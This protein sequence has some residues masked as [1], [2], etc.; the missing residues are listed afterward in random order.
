MSKT[1]IAA[2]RRQLEDKDRQIAAL[3]AQVHK[4]QAAAQQQQQQ[5]PQAAFRSHSSPDPSVTFAF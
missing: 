1:L 4:L 2:L 3:K 5:P